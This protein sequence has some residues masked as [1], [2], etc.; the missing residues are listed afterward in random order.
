[1]A[2]EQIMITPPPLN[3]WILKVVVT[4]W[5]CFAR[6]FYFL[7]ATRGTLLCLLLP[8]LAFAQMPVR[9]EL[10]IDSA[11]GPW[12]GDP[13]IGEVR[14]VSAVTGTGDLEELPLG[15]E[16]RL[17]PGWKI[18]WRTP[19]E[20]GLPPTLDLQLANGD[21]VQH[22][23]N[24]PVPK[25]FNAFGFDNFGYENAIILPVTLTGHLKGAAIQIVGQMEALVCANICVPLAGEVGLTIA[26]GQATPSSLAMQIARY[27]AKVPRSG[28]ASIIAVE[29]IWQDKANLNVQFSKNGPDIDEIFV[30]GAAGIA[31]KKPVYA[32]GV[33]TMALEGKLDLPLAGQMLD[34]TVVAGDVFIT[35]RHIVENVG[36]DALPNSA[37]DD[38]SIWAIVAFAFFG[39]L[40]LNLM[41]CVLP[42]LAIKL[43]KIIDASG[44]SLAC[45]RMRFAAGALGIL[46]SFG[47]LAT[48]LVVMRF[49]GGQIG[50]GIQ[51]QSPFFLALM[52]LILGLF[53][54]NMLDR[55]F[56]SVPLFVQKE[57]W[58][59]VERDASHDMLKLM[60]GDFM[61]GMLATLLATPCSAPFVGSAITIAL[62]GDTTRLFGI[63]MAMGTG[64]ATPWVLVALF[65]NLVLALP[66]PGPWMDWLKRGLA[67]LLIITMVWIGSLL[68]ATQGGMATF[69]LIGLIIF[70][71]F[72][73]L[74]RQKFMII[75]AGAS[76]L[77][78]LWLLPRPA[79]IEPFKAVVS[80]WQKWSPEVTEF[81]KK[82][83]KVVLI[84]VTAD[85]CITCQA[86]KRL[87]LE[88]APIAGIIEKLLADGKLVML[89]ADWTRPDPNI[90]T[91]LSS[92]QRFGIPFN[93]VY[94]PAAPDGIV[95]GELLSADKV[96]Q[97]LIDAALAR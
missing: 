84:D 43:A 15:L 85:W 50:W 75:L 73:V 59:S 8:L 22:E 91:F 57:V 39:G 27:K 89:Q 53:T 77:S 6:W 41:P 61:G 1:M 49:V 36:D 33:A 69:V 17:A 64:L 20:A 80:G 81:A 66:K 23:I 76:L 97:A 7:R 67:G 31:F 10:A 58:P 82:D 88:R 90:L 71:L 83:G 40:I 29:R 38:K 60:A 55:F 62:T 52:L 72:T 3:K 32:N 92:Y 65:P 48:G 51:F 54:L 35:N 47:I 87:V 70:V 74:L 21:A 24:W 28:G 93:I 5:K 95:L 34:L 30:E 18:Y 2:L 96:E 16:F 63:F 11:T 12:V 86:N 4:F 19:G 13:T 42:V 25:R 56:F 14:L 68:N 45:I 78:G 26:D 94:G 44:Q 46:A 37:F 9:A 79:V